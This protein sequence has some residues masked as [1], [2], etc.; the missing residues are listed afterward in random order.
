MR[1]SVSMTMVGWS[2]LMINLSTLTIRLP[3][4]TPNPNVVHPLNFFTY[5]PS[6]I[7]FI[8]NRACD[9]STTTVQLY[10][11]FIGD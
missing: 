7:V 10:Q 6:S 9:A 1:P 8:G 3:Q 5:S 11:I 4:N 2:Q